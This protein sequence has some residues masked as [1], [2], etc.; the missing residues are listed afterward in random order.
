M[1]PRVPVLVGSSP[2]ATTAEKLQL[3]GRWL[4]VCVLPTKPLSRSIHPTVGP[5][6]SPKKHVDAAKCTRRSTRRGS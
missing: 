5:G 2:S 3:I 1:R 6:R 4:P